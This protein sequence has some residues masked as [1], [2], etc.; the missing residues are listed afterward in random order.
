MTHKNQRFV[1][2]TIGGPVEITDK[3]KTFLVVG[4][5]RWV[6][7]EDIDTGISVQIQHQTQFNCLLCR[8]RRGEKI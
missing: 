2:E 7:I 4:D 6:E 1:V 5:D 8:H 3:T